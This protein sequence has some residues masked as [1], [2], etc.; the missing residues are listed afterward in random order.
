MPP[1]SLRI[2]PGGIVN[3][4]VFSNLHT[5]AGFQLDRIYPLAVYIGAVKGTGIANH[6]TVRFAHKD[7]VFARNGNV[8]KEN[9]AFGFAPYCDFFR[10]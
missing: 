5:I 4:P 2:L 6:I 1:P 7:G 3:H 10:V 8:I 9:V